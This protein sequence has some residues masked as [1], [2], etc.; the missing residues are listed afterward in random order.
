M[1]C[2][3]SELDRRGMW[4]AYLSRVDDRRGS[5]QREERRRPETRRVAAAARETVSETER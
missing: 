4:N 3:T 1:K 2:T 5:C